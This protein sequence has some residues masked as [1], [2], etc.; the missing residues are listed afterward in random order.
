MRLPHA[1]LALVL[2]TVGTAVHAA[3]LSALGQRWRDAT[4]RPATAGF[5]KAADATH[6]ALRAYC[7]KPGEATRATVATRFDALAEAWGR[8]EVLRFGPLVEA[9]RFERVF[10]FPDPRGLVQ[11][12]VSALLA[13]ADPAV[14]DAGALASRSVGVQGIPALE[15]ALFAGEA[16]AQ[17]AA[18]DDA[19]RYRCAYATAVAA[20]LGTTAREI[21]AGWSDTSA[22]ARAFA[23]P[24]AASA[25]YRTP[26][27]VAAE[28]LKAIS[29][30]LQYVRDIKLAPAIG[31]TPEAARGQ[32]A[33]LWR[34]GAT[35][36]LLRGNVAGVRDL[37][38]AARFDEAIAADQRWIAASLRDEAGR[39]LEDIDAVTLP[40]DRAVTDA[41]ARE[42]LVHALFVLKNMK[43]ITDEFLAA[44]LG[45]NIGF[46]AFDGD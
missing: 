5:S 38:V 16:A 46:N 33:P 37:V 2:A 21:D 19:G 32:R 18:A 24:D 45:V 28:T 41:D 20:Q 29:G 7:A 39:V 11:R 26:Q 14:L 9:N 17:I 1:I 35:R 23:E 44:A 27:E 30:S 12:Q 25:F 40:F 15:H 42:R 4:I 8:V 6:E 13:A 43:S 22:L 10:F 31:D 34:S 3:D 36:A